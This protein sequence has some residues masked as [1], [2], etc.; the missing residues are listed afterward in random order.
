MTITGKIKALFDTQQISEKFK[1]R[2]FVVT[3]EGEYPEHLKL[4]FHQDKCDLLDGVPI[5]QEVTVSINLKGREWINP[6]GETK[7]FN[8]LQAYA[9][10][11]QPTQ[12]SHGYQVN[13]NPVSEVTNMHSSTGDTIN[14]NESEIPF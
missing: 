12:S 9:I 6:Q 2:D 8:T 1:K 3:V 14:D 13:P 11:W 7:Y 10:N 5:G 4:E